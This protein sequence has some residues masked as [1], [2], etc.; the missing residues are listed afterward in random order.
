MALS[1]Y[2]KCKLLNNGTKLSIP[3]LT[4][5]WLDSEVYYYQ[6]KSHDRLDVL[7][8]EDFGSES[9]FWILARMNH[10]S[11]FFDLKEGSKIIRPRNPST[12]LNQI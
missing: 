8:L 1:R 5:T 6:V 2:R 12:F 11:F 3:D 10:I 9:Y 4:F 7:A